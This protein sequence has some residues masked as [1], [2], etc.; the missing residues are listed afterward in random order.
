MD[1]ETVRTVAL[2]ALRFGIWV[3]L[4]LILYVALASSV[5]LD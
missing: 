5:M 2:F 3:G 1:P 4:G